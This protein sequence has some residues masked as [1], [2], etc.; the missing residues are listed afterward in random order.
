MPLIDIASVDAEIGRRFLW[1][2]FD[3]A[4]ERVF[5]QDS[6]DRCR[7]LIRHNFIGIAVYDLFILADRLLVPDVFAFSMVVH[8]AAMTPLMLAVNY[9]LTLRPPVWLRE[10]LAASTIVLATY[11]ILLLMLLSHAPLRTSEHLSIVLVI[12][13]GT[14]IQTIRFWYVLVACLACL[15][16]YVAGLWHLFAGEPERT[17]VA[18]SVFAVVVLFSLVGCY[19]LEHAQRMGFLLRLR[20]RLR[21][22]ELEALSC[23]DALTG[24][25]N[26]RALE[27]GLARAGVDAEA[28]PVAVLLCDID[29]FKAFND[30]NGHLVGDACLRQVA[31]LI[32][33]E[34]R[35]TD[36]A[37]YRFGGE[38]FLVL[39][40]GT[41]ANAA[42][43]VAERIR[44]AVARAAI[45][46]GT[47]HGTHVTISIGHAAGRIACADDASALIAGADAALYVAKG[48]GRD[49]VWPRPAIELSD[50]AA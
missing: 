32:A 26:R 35:K 1:L 11:S 38:E 12:L 48:R 29:H 41:D 4:L 47:P 16:L 8:F 50:R 3:A 9:T 17:L 36:D 10:G 23:R 18:G 5:E 25:G 42:V 2:R 39:L 7:S 46:S 37:A 19:N 45:I 15:G 43:I 30:A 6:V 33:G 27:L 14:M 34:L 31:G 49:Q 20:D 40:N 24:V 13:F 22:N 28:L 21:L 44:A